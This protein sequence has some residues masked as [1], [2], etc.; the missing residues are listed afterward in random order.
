[1]TVGMILLCVCSMFLSFLEWWHPL[2]CS[3][4]IV[5]YGLYLIYDVQLIAGGHQH[6]LSYDEYIVG[7]MV[8][9]I[10]IMMLF[11]EL[12]RLLGDKK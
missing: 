10:D 7:A 8:I 1:M 12:L 5:I 11:I 2:V 3:F 9:Y 4:I 6:S